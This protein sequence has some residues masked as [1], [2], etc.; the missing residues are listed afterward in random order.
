MIVL[1]WSWFQLLSPDTQNTALAQA[2]AVECDAAKP[3][4]PGD[5]YGERCASLMTAIAFRETEFRHG[6]RGDHGASRCE[7]QIQD[8]ARVE[9][10][11]FTCVR[12]GIQRV[13]ES[14][15]LCPKGNELC[16]YAAG[17][18]GLKEAAQVTETISRDRMALAKWLRANGMRG[19]K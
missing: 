8:D 10:D 5:V 2:I 9:D 19:N 11:P 7:L 12:V 16:I 14:M 1:I 6:V 3:L 15:A 4:W 17:P 13:R 18:R